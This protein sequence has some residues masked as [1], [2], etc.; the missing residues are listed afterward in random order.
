MGQQAPAV[1]SF[2][3][4]AIKG[5]R[6]VWNVVDYLCLQAPASAWRNAWRFGPC[7]LFVS[8][9]PPP[10]RPWTLRFNI[11]HDL[12][13]ALAGISGVLSAPASTT[14][15]YISGAGSHCCP[16]PK[17][18]FHQDFERSLGQMYSPKRAALRQREMV[19]TGKI[20]KEKTGEASSRPQR[21]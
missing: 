17:I 20:R 16:R 6:E 7:G 9:A 15:V 10:K 1:F 12:V 4:A 11:R 19:A 14:I 3:A 5:G 2:L 13:L 8:R 21:I 18:D